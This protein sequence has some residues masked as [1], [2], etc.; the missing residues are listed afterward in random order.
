[1]FRWFITLCLLLNVGYVV[2]APDD[3][4]NQARVKVTDRSAPVFQQALKEGLGAVLIKVSGN[5]AIMTLPQIRNSL[6]QINSYVVSY[7]YLQENDPQTTQ[8]QLYLQ[9]TYDEKNVKQLLENTKQAIWKGERPVTLIILSVDAASGRQILASDSNNTLITTLNNAANERGLKIMFP[10][11]DLEDQSDIGDP[12]QTQLSEEELQKL[13][14]RYHVTSIL[15]GSVKHDLSSYQ[16]NW[17]FWLRNALSQW[18]TSGNNIQA[19]AIEGLGRLMETLANQFATVNNAQ[20]QSEFLVKITGVNGLRDYL[21]VLNTLQHLAP[22]SDA[23]VKDLNA[24]EITLA[25]KT[26]GG[27]E[28]LAQ[29][30]R[31]NSAL[32][33]EAGPLTSAPNAANLFFRWIPTTA[34]VTNDPISQSILQENN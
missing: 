26:A 13:A 33:E 23:Q 30:L 19:I 8:P 25:I 15:F 34:P 17:Q 14:E 7:S 24:D 21:Q 28:A 22:V 10:V 27:E 2:A 9:V 32:K 18:N 16:I 12:N 1:M 3:D 5:P 11:M 4:L 6:E 20:T 31:G 29:A